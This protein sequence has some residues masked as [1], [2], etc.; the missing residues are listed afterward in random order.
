[1]VSRPRKWVMNKHCHV[2]FDHTITRFLHQNV[3][4]I[5]VFT[6]IIDF[7][8]NKNAMFH[9]V[10]K[11]SNIQLDEKN[12]MVWHDK[13]SV[14]SSSLDRASAVYYFQRPFS[15][16]ICCK[17]SRSS[18]MREGKISSMKIKFRKS[19]ESLIGLATSSLIRFTLK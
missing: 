8:M 10:T 12:N 1:M 9:S 19:Y 17:N 16:C 2:I 7:C 3:K 15:A 18:I 4:I 11:N 5:I 14:L 13:P 6:D